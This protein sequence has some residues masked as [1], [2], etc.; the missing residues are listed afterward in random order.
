MLK[1]NRSTSR[2]AHSEVGALTWLSLASYKN[3]SW[4]DNLS[5]GL[6]NSGH[7]VFLRHGAVL[8]HP[9]FPSLLG[10]DFATDKQFH[11]AWPQI[12]VNIG[13]IATGTVS[14]QLVVSPFP[15]HGN[16]TSQGVDRAQIELQAKL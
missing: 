13:R 16:L 1:H 9:S 15:L 5:S 2:T 11:K 4:M 6:D 14:Y 8:S 12:S 3:Q 10:G 7:R